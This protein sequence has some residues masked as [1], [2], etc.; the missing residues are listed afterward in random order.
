MNRSRGQQTLFELMR[1]RCFGYV[2]GW[3]A[4]YC[5]ETEIRHEP[6]FFVVVL[7]FLFQ[8]RC[9]TRMSFPPSSP[10]TGVPQWPWLCLG[11][12][13]QFIQLAHGGHRGI[14]FTEARGTSR[15][16]FSKPW[17]A[18]GLEMNDL[19]V[20]VAIDRIFIIGLNSAHLLCSCGEGK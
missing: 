2:D 7:L 13:F 1:S 6:A 20:Y 3:P 14:F 10:P 15:F 12:T 18:P 16:H 8:V 19:D 9:G 11:F 17:Y 5:P 4:C